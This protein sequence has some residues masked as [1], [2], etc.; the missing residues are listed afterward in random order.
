[1]IAA[2]TND[3]LVHTWDLARATDVDVSLDPELT[4]IAYDA[5]LASRAGRADSAMFAPEVDVPT[6]ADTI[7]KLLA[8]HGRSPT[9]PTP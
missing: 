8:L 1:M 7:S 6:D 4:S 5:A 2:L 3:V 9:W